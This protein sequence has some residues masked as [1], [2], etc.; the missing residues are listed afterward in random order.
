MIKVGVIGGGQL[1]WMMAKEAPKLGIELIVQ[2]PSV[3]DSA[4]SLSKEAI[5]APV[6]SAEA[7]AELAKKC[8]VIT[9]ENE[10]VDLPSLEK[11][12]NQG[13]CFRPSLSSLKPLLDKYD[14][15]CFLQNICLP[16]PQFKAYESTLDLEQFSPPL[17]I[18]ARRHGYDGYGTVIVKSAD[19]LENTLTKFVE[20][21][22]LIEEFVNFTQELAVMACRSVTGEIKIYPVTETKQKQQVCRYVIAPAQLQPQQVKEIEAIATKLL[23]E[24][25]YVGVLGIELFLTSEG[26]I[27]VNEIAPRTHNSGHYSLDACITSQFAIQ[28]QAVTKQQLGDV[29]LKN[30]GAVM[31]NLLGLENQTW[32]DY[33]SKLTQISQIPNTFIHWY[34]KK[35]LREGRKLG[36][37][38]VIVNQY[39]SVEE[40]CYKKSKLI[41]AQIENIWYN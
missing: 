24:L 27:L 9:F 22:V 7:T 13:V 28:L 8:D 41:T 3:D 26:K 30:Q 19:E 16:V 40:D 29:K 31:V 33:Q 37:V 34:Q 14:Q 20:T 23:Q 25:D 12:A 1:A 5:L 32:I 15:R 6:D 4:V 10:F 35:E 11:L 18:K 21:P 17:V 39:N 2:T 38:N 36:H